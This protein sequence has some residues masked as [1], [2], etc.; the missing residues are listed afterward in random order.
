MSTY[1]L[2]NKDD[3]SEEAWKAESF[4]AQQGVNAIEAVSLRLRMVSL[5]QRPDN[6]IPGCKC[7]LP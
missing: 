3:S 5:G 4:L 1:M 6:D 2:R 7:T